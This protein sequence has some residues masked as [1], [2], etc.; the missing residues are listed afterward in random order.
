MEADDQ[1]KIESFR[2]CKRVKSFINLEADILI[3][4]MYRAW[5]SYFLSANLKILFTAANSQSQGSTLQLQGK[6]V[7]SASMIKVF[8]S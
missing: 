2:S 4:S 7:I 3:T 6:I 1:H 8:N 5:K